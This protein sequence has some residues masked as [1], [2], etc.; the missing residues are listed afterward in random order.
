[1][2]LPQ[3]VNS[4]TSHFFQSPNQSANLQGN[5][6]T[7][8]AI[9]SIFAPPTNNNNKKPNYTVRTK[10]P[11]QF[12]EDEEVEDEGPSSK[13]EIDS[14]SSDELLHPNVGNSGVRFGS[15]LF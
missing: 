7:P 11:I 13:I 8:K 10:H 9:F 12:D 15:S 4:E 3:D 14:Q 2:G 1:V 5:Q 6:K